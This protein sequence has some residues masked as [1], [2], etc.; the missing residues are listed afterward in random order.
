MPISM[1]NTQLKAA[2][3]AVPERYIGFIEEIPGTNTQGNTLDEARMNLREA[4]EL[5]LE[6]NRELAERSLG[7]RQMYRE[8]LEMPHR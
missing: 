4:V 3:I 5:V 2:F 1:P 7:S 8:R 6:A